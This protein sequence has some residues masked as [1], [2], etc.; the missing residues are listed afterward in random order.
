[1]LADE[2]DYVVGVDT[3]LDEHVLAV[4]AAATGAVLARAGGR[5]KYAWLPGGAALRG[6]GRERR[7]CLGDRG[8]GQLRRR[9]RALPRRP[10][11]EGARGQPHTANGAT[12]ARQGRRARRGPYG[13]GGTCQRDARPSAQR[14]ATRG[15][16]V[17]VG[18]APKRCRRTPRSA[19]TASRRDRHRPR[20]A[21]RR[22]AAAP[23]RQAAR[24]LQPP[25][26]LEHNRR[27][28]RD[29][30][31]LAQSRPQ[32]QRRNPGSGRARAG[33]PQPCTGP[34]A[35][36]ARRP[37][38][39]PDRRPASTDLTGSTAAA[40]ANSTVRCTGSQ[41]PGA[42]P[43][44]RACLPRTQTSRRQ[45]PTRSNPPPEAAARTH[46]LHHPQERAPLDRGAT[47]SHPITFSLVPFADSRALTVQERSLSAGSF[48]GDEP[49]EFCLL[50][51]DG[52][53]DGVAP[54]VRRGTALDLPR[55]EPLRSTGRP[56]HSRK[57]ASPRLHA[58]YRDGARLSRHPELLA[59][60]TPHLGGS[61]SRTLCDLRGTL[62]GWRTTFSTS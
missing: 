44:A 9:A 36:T 6:R 18:R 52:W 38:R 13:T 56:T 28:A 42:R 1:M 55:L 20:P 59:R 10:W 19:R 40:T 8:H 61:G 12:P 54:L 30:A 26:P 50:Q 47:L 48:D 15:A 22:A 35:R 16:A 21:A 58:R 46:R 32:N 45:E 4:V 11:R 39:R 34:R 25:P 17:V 23:D 14:G 3:H 31:R 41:S 5:G 29:T 49:V 62:V 60:T 37:R 24:A 33:D 53:L 51:T 43:P 57:G 2:L 7:A 27:R